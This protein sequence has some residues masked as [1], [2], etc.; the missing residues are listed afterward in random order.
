VR[1]GFPALRTSAAAAIARID[2]GVVAA[3]GRL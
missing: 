1:D 2:R 3:G